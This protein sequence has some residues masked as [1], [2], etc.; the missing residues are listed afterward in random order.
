M[1][2]I[3]NA[4]NIRLLPLVVAAAGA[5]VSLTQ[6]AHAGGAPTTAPAPTPTQ[7]NLTPS[8]E[9]YLQA[10]GN[11]CMAR[12]DWPIDVRAA[13]RASRSRDSVQLPVLESLG[14]VKSSP[15][16]DDPEVTRYQLTDKGRQSYLTQKISVR[17]RQGQPIEHSGDFCPA[18]LALDRIVSWESTGTGEQAQLTVKYTYKVAHAAEWTSDPAAREVFPM[19]ARLL[20]GAGK[21][22]LEQAF[23]WSGRAWEALSPTD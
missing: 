2:D 19:M 10:R 1:S 21:M 18:H 4:Q 14:V 16:P 22:E 7:Q 13:D 15:L 17:G 6:A 5:A 23:H 20:D 12:Y 9:K 11:F 3:V 8:V